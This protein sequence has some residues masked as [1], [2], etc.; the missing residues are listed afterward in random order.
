MS[1]FRA[2]DPGDRR[3]A[4]P[5]PADPHDRPAAA[6]PVGMPLPVADAVG[7]RR[8]LIDLV[9]YAFDRARTPAVQ[10]RLAA[11]LAGIG[12]QVVRP[13]GSPFDP[14]SHEAGGILPT[15]DPALHNLIAETECAGF[16]DGERIVREPV[17][18]VYRLSAQV[19]AGPVRKLTGP[20][21]TA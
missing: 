17:V 1:W 7:D 4:G 12:V 10:E 18:V 3:T 16:R 19:E 2:A 5:P 15:V 20:E 14:G 9:I 13:D 8:L 6:E 11:G 21:S